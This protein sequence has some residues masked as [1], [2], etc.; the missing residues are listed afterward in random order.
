M[1]ERGASSKYES[2]LHT[3]HLP[4][5]KYSSPLSHSLSLTNIESEL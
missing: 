5:V 2:D 3:R 4:L 1:G